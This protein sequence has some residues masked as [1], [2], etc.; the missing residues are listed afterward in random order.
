MHTIEPEKPSG[1]APAAAR[2]RA[3]LL[4]AA[5]IALMEVE[6]QRKLGW[7][8]EISQHSLEILTSSQIE[9]AASERGREDFHQQAG[10]LARDRVESLWPQISALVKRLGAVPSFADVET[11]PP[12]LLGAPILP[13]GRDGSDE[14]ASTIAGI[15][16]AAT[17][18]LVA[19]GLVGAE[20][21]GMPV[22]VGYSGVA[23]GG[24]S[25]DQGAWAEVNLAGGIA[26][27]LLGGAAADG[28]GCQ[29]RAWHAVIDALGP[30][31]SGLEGPTAE[32][33][34]RTGRFD[35]VNAYLLARSERVEELIRHAIQTGR[36]DAEADR[37][38]TE[39]RIDIAPPIPSL[40]R[41]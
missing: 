34:R 21:A 32:V 38:A 30:W 33:L 12:E 28:C 25:L 23:I 14:A 41:G 18:H 4:A 37:L 6:V 11:L 10:L 22:S 17:C 7:N 3:R 27:E 24:A 40:S 13:I 5:S 20:V 2:P 36:L 1:A 8:Q 15:Y 19:H 16:R 35:E 39:G 9:A 31:P 26:D 29:E